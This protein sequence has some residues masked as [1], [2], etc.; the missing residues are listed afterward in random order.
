MAHGQHKTLSTYHA[1]LSLL[2]VCAQTH[3]GGYPRLGK[4]WNCFIYIYIHYV[5][6]RILR[7]VLTSFP[8]SISYY[9][10]QVHFPNGG[11][12]SRHLVRL[13]E[14]TA[15]PAMLLQ[16]PAAPRKSLPLFLM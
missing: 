3:M 14:G 13:A 8:L 11:R 4:T 6:I 2:L 15:R 10:L 16:G 5:Y 7:G 1:C 9:V 12:G